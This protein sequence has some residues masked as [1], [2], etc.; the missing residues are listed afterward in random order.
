MDAINTAGQ[1]EGLVFTAKA[2]SIK[3]Q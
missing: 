3:A 1:A 2:L